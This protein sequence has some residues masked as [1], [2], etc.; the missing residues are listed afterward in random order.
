MRKSTNSIVAFLD[1]EEQIVYG[2]DYYIP[3]SVFATL[4]RAFCRMFTFKELPLNDDNISSPL[5]VKG[6]TRS[7]E[8][9]MWEDAPLHGVFIMGCKPPQKI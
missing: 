8:T 5:D 4:Y 2:K 7:V 9:L 1:T 3:L 6:L